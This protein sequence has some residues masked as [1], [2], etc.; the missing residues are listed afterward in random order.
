VWSIE[1]LRA[2]HA[3]MAHELAPGSERRLYHFVA[4]GLMPEAAEEART[5]A[6]GLLADGR[7]NE[8]MA[9]LQ[10][11]LPAV[12]ELVDGTAEAAMLD[13][14]LR[15]ALALEQVEALDDWLYHHSRA[16]KAATRHLRPELALARAVA[17]SMRSRDEAT[18][19]EVLAVPPMGDIV[20][21]AARWRQR[22]YVARA[23]GAAAE[24]EQLA[25]TLAWADAT[26]Q[27][28]ARALV[29]VCQGWSHYLQ[30]RYQEAADCHE[31][32]AGRAVPAHTRVA[33]LLNA[34][35]ARMETG[36]LDESLAVALRL[37][38]LAAERRLAAAEARAWWL[39]RAIHYRTGN[40][41]GPD[42]ELC[43]AVAAAGNLTTDMVVAQTEAAFAWR[44]GD[45]ETARRLARYSARIAAQAQ[46]RAAL[47][48]ARLIGAAA[49]ATLNDAERADCLA[50]CESCP[51]AAMRL[52]VAALCAM[53][54]A[55]PPGLAERVREAANEA[56]VD[57]ASS[58]RL[59]VL[60]PAEADALLATM[61]A[62]GSVTCET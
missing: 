45:D 48:V 57:L 43:A 25:A 10:L 29:D 14:L 51:D 35:S 16:T 22:V 37:L 6:L 1:Q 59:D 4:A 5:S 39:V 12:R 41:G 60:S 23:R 38:D 2:A 28:V 50:F 8:A 44:N 55:L 20:F 21:D 58:Q 52:Q 15:V 17:A 9:L 49:G 27:P 33:A 26:D 54:F 32:A 3:K 24:A 40:G 13:A 36:Q 19:C 46:A 53:S 61:A 47:V 30:G 42:L 34:A 31:R 56:G 7:P 11:A 18:L 62:V